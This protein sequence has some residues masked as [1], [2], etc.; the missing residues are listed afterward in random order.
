M[1]IKGNSAY[2]MLK[3]RPNIG[4]ASSENSGDLVRRF[5]ERDPSALTDMYNLYWRLAYFLIAR[6]VDNAE[7]AEDLVQECFLR[8]WDRPALLTGNDDH[9]LGQLLLGIARNRALEYVEPATSAVVRFSAPNDVSPETAA[10]FAESVP[11]LSQQHQQVMDLAYCKDVSRK[12]IREPKSTEMSEG[13]V[14]ISPI[15]AF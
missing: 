2:Q 12:S 7:V 13:I 5:R 10:L 3:K 8:A 4:D 15:I 11:D 1:F 9:A 6:L 14:P